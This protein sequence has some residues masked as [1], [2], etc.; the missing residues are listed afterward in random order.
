MM[1]FYTLAKYCMH[2]TMIQHGSM[3]Y[4]S[5]QRFIVAPA[6]P[7]KR[8]EIIVHFMHSIMSHYPTYLELP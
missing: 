8:I 6:A 7:L 5:P 4:S 2:A 3:R 1:F